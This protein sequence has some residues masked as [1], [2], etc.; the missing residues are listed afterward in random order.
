[1]RPLALLLTLLFAASCQTASALESSDL[2]LSGGKIF[3]ADPTNPWAEAIA[4]RGTRI[5]AVGTERQ[6]RRLAGPETRVIDLAGRLV[7]PGINDAH[8]HEP[9]RV[10]SRSV[11]LSRAENIADVLETVRATVLE[12]PLGERITGELP[13][14]LLDAPGLTRGVIDAVA[15]SHPVELGVIGGHAALFNTSALARAGIAESA[16][17]PRRGWFGRRDG[18][19]DG[20]VYEHALWDTYAR[21][22]ADAPDDAILARLRAVSAEAAAL[23]ITTLQTM[24]TVEPARLEALLARAELPVR[25]R[26][27][28]LQIE[29]PSSLPPTHPVKYILDGTPMERN[30]AMTQPWSDRSGSRGVLA[31]TDA[32]IR[33]ILREAAAGRPTLLHAVGDDAMRRILQTMAAIHADWPS[34]R[35]RIEHGEGLAPDLLPEARRLGVVIV[36][37]PSHFMLPETMHARLGSQRMAWF[38]PVRTLLDRRIRFALGSDG[39]LNPWLNVMFAAMNPTR[40]GEVLDRVQAVTAYTH[41][42]A[43]AEFQEAQ[44]G[45]LVRGRL[46]DLA[47]LSQD[48]FTVPLEQLPATQSELTLVGG[49]IVFEREVSESV[50]EE[51]SPAD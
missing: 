17:D 33:A 43:F 47:V 49:K 32:E 27:I 11:G 23:G 34:R 9:W 26:I 22:I 7:V 30:A 2:I 39:P 14:A 37:N 21:A 44:K 25:W 4:I 10:E 38:Q 8:V 31:Y 29:P 6:I 36:Q 42:S 12:T 3:T 5:S 46:A 35:V 20:W 40:P 28:A 41:G 50:G 45:T 13:I 51:S 15:P 19:L 24:S 18:R 16:P 48:I 1:M